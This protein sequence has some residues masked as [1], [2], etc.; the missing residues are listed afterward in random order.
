MKID[1]PGID[2]LKKKVDRG[3]VSIDEVISIIS[4]VAKGLLRAQEKGI[5][6]RDIKPGKGC[7]FISMLY[8]AKIFRTGK[9][10]VE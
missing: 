7:I 1:W 6:H 8:R 9:I 5:I 2:V 3:D 10:I 4:Q